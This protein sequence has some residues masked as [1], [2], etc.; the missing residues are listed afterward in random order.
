MKKQHGVLALEEETVVETT[1]IIG[2]APE[3]IPTETEI[4][5]EHEA[6]QDEVEEIADTTDTL[7][8]AGVMAE[9]I[10]KMSDVT[11]QSIES[12]EGLAQPT[13]EVMEV[14]MEHFYVRLGVKKRATPALE[15]YNSDRLGSSKAALEGLQELNQRIDRQLS[16]AQE[17]M[18]ARIANAFSRIFTTSGKM[19][20]SAKAMK[21]S[22]L[23][24]V[25]ELGSPAWARIFSASGKTKVDAGDVVSVFNKFMD[26]IDGEAAKL[27]DDAIK[28]LRTIS[29]EQG[30]ATFSSAV[31][32][33]EVIEKLEK[34][35]EDKL[36][37]LDVKLAD[38]VNN[39]KDVSITSCDKTS[40]DK[41]VKLIE[42]STT[43]H[44]LSNKIDETFEL[45]YSLSVGNPAG[46]TKEGRAVRKM[47]TG[48]GSDLYV[49]ALKLTHGQ[50][51]CTHGAYKYLKA[52][53]K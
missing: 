14:A 32:A 39:K 4:D 30:R 41:I 3:A 29:H 10:D 52:S 2:E 24:E 18:P 36:K 33:V 43:D 19:Y 48:I 35:L 5:S 26:A 25:R 49:L 1:A 37:K 7:E 40:F 47:I 21:A 20:K 27:L 44:R 6:I 17:G 50:I 12:G 34:D 9:A 11:E 28:V 15:D 22:D 16:V 45:I 51:A 42:R 38:R 53:V 13:V 31:G 23:G 46:F 8:E